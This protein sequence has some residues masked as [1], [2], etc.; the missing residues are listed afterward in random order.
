MHAN[1]PEHSKRDHGGGLDAAMAEF[2]GTRSDWLDLSTGIN[3]IPWPLPEF[4]ADAWMRLPDSRAVNQLC[5]AARQFWNV[6]EGADVLPCHGASAA[7]ARLPALMKGREVQIT[8]PTYNEHAASFRNH[9][10][11]VVEDNA[12]TRV[13]VHP[14]NPDGRLWRRDELT[15]DFTV[16]DESFC[17]VCPEESHIARATTPGTIILKSFGKFWGLA[18]MRLGFAIGDPMMIAH[19]R[20]I[21][22]PWSVSGPALEA[23]E[24]ALKDLTWAQETRARLA[25]D[26]AR[27][28][29]IMTTAGAQNPRGTTL[30]RLYEVADAKALQNH[31][32]RHHIWT[33]IFP[34]SETYIRLGL[35][36]HPHEWAQ[37]ETA[38]AEMEHLV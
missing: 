29:A 21:L 9:A 22:G 18:G 4:S 10:W 20:E 25:T 36:G 3:P 38:I 15:T 33:R 5:D 31:M 16:I 35:P 37:L 13:V 34:Y 7:I 19:L 12:D 28:D 11:Q 8:T 32:A 23:G 2:G 17:D 1:Q 26:T 6:P 27:L 14:N 24:K 30:F